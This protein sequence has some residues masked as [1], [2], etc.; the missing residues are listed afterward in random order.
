MCAL[1][2][3]HSWA[4]GILSICETATYPELESVRVPRRVRLLQLH[5]TELVLM[6]WTEL[7]DDES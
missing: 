3:L 7:R 6:A 4:F 5:A 2:R 1:G